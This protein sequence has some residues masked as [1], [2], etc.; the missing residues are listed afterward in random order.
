[1]GRRYLAQ[2]QLATN[3]SSL[4]LSSPEFLGEGAAPPKQQPLATC[5][6]RPSFCG[7]SRGGCE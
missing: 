4:A 6:V 1:M 2:V 3:T 7:A 5:V